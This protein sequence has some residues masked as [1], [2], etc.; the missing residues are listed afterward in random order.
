MG[1]LRV[2]SLFCRT[3]RTSFPPEEEEGGRGG[4]FLPED[5]DCRYTGGKLAVEFL[6][7]MANTGVCAESADAVH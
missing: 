2:F 4:S 3:W 5:S 1:A 6:C 7:T